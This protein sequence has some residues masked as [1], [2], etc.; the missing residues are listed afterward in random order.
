MIFALTDYCN[1]IFQ[2]N[3]Y[4]PVVLNSH[5]LKI[6]NKENFPSFENIP[7]ISIIYCHTRGCFNSWLV[8]YYTNSVLSHT[9]MF[10][11][12]GLL[13]DV[14]TSGVIQHSASDY[15]DNK[16]YL[17]ILSIQKT[18]DEINE[19]LN[20][21]RS[22]IGCDFNWG[23]IFYFWLLILFGNN[24]EWRLKHSLDVLFI[25]LIFSFINSGFLFLGFVY[26]ILTGMFVIKRMVLE[27]EKVY[28]LKNEEDSF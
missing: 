9:A 18:K 6:A 26:V 12:N 21:A 14:T 5:G 17:I 4:S 8:M 25:I 27:N 28:F 7:P 16:S 22:M 1:Y 15:L 19:C 10:L 13:L 3:K 11:E 24:E 23:G 2:K 20:R